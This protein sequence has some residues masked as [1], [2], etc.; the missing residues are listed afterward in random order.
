MLISDLRKMLDRLPPEYDDDEVL[1]D[2][3]TAK[4][5]APLSGYIGLEK[6]RISMLGI[7]LNAK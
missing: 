3:H 1:V 5:Q 6:F 7:V 4:D 2:L